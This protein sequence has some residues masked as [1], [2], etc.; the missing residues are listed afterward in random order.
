V[1]NEKGMTLIE[2]MIVVA[3]IG[4]LM[5]VLGGRV[6]GNLERSKVSQAKIHMREIQKQLEMYYLQCNQYPTTEEGLEALVS[7]P[8]SCPGWGPEPYLKSV[9]KDPWGATYIYE[10]NGGSF[11]ITSMGKDRRPG[12]EGY[13]ADIS[14]DQLE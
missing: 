14:S 4:G 6:M 13:D 11:T 3:I 5:A 2:I 7:A 9:P 12:G 1:R 8:A 10:S